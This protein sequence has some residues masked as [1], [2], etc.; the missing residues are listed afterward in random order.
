MFEFERTANNSALIVKKL[1]DIKGALEKS[2]DS[3]DENRHIKIRNLAIH[4]AEI[5]YQEHDAWLE[6]METQILGI[7][8]LIH[9]LE[10][11]VHYT[12]QANNDTCHSNA[13]PRREAYLS[14][15]I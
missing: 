3:N 5:M 4:T 1:K 13:E 11:G 10:I 14:R 6:L 15:R 9:C 2:S 12:T 8:A 7:P